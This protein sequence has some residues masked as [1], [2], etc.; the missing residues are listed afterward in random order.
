MR[1]ILEHR[2][3]R[4]YKNDPIPQEHIELILKAAIRAST[5][6]NMQLYSIIV[7]TDQAIKEKLWEVHFK[8][9]MVK[10]APLL[11]TFCADIRRFEKWC[12]LHGAKHNY[13]NI[14]WF[15]NSVTDALLAAQN[16]ALQ[17]ESLDYGI[18][19]LGTTLYNADKIIEILNLPDGVFPIT[20]LV[21]G[22]P[23]EKPPLTDRLPLNAVIHYQ[24]YKDY[25]QEDIIKIYYEKENS[26]FYK[27]IVEQNNVP[28]LAHVFTDKRYTENDNIFFSEKIINILKKLKFI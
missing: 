17:A 22:I 21:I 16:A 7:T 1:T 9:D 27:K 13:R 11:L 2:T 10:E 15:L 19:Y 20:S 24:T 12:D 18:C 25:N 5:T 14:L 8:Q 28:S 26:D 4:K 6:G 3:I 23:N